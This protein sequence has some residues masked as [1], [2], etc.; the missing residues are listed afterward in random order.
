M[1]YESFA[2]DILWFEF[3]CLNKKRSAKLI[4]VFEICIDRIKYLDLLFFNKIFLRIN[5]KFRRK[6]GSQITLF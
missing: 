6:V 2:L 1:K 5:L 3:D 4:N